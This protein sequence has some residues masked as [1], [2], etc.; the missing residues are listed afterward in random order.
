MDKELEEYI[1]DNGF[2]PVSWGSEWY[3]CS[4]GHLWNIDEIEKEMNYEKAKIRD[5][6]PTS[7]EFYADAKAEFG[8]VVE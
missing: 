2:T 6:M 8:E 1:E 7:E 4:G 3:Q 5:L